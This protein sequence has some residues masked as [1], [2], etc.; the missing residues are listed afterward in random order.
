LPQAAGYPE[1]LAQR[2][3]ALRASIPL[4]AAHGDLTMW[5]VLIDDAFRLGIV[6]WSEAREHSL[7]LADFYYAMADAVAVAR[8]WSWARA[9]EACFTPRGVYAH[10]ARAL[11][12]RPARSLCLTGAAS[13]LCLHA[14]FLGHA[15]NEQRRGWPGGAKPFL[16]AVEW[17]A[18]NRDAVGNWMSEWT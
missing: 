10:R 12:Q 18:L 16:R 13:E 6:D 11:L 15:V 17:L 8:G 7:P 1:W 5:N 4:V 9:C 14:C 2:C 3:S